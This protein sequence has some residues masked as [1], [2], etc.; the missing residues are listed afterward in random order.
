MVDCLDNGRAPLLLLSFAGAPWVGLGGFLLFGGF[1][2]RFIVTKRLVRSFPAALWLFARINDRHAPCCRCGCECR[3]GPVD[4]VARAGNTTG[5][6]WPIDIRGRQ[7]CGVLGL[8]HAPVFDRD[9]RGTLPLLVLTARSESNPSRWLF[10]SESHPFFQRRS[11]SLP[12]VS[13]RVSAGAE[14]LS[15]S[16]CADE[17]RPLIGELP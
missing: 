9:V 1:F 16:I 13:I 17:I 2:P 11:L 3:R 10:F 14:M 4:R 15:R 6:Q 8:S 5:S 7:S 12:Y